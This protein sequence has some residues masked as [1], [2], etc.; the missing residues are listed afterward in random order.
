MGNEESWTDA[1]WNVMPK[2][3]LVKIIVGALCGIAGIGAGTYAYVHYDAND[4]SLHRRRMS[5]NADLVQQYQ[6][7]HEQAVKKSEEIM[8]QLEE[9]AKVNEDAEKKMFPRK[10]AEK[11]EEKKEEK[12]AKKL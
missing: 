10:K 7:A 6:Q 9:N 5:G 4:L 11:K 3:S 1:I 12:K 8:A 2:K